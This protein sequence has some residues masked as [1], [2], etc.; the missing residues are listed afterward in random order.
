MNIDHVTDSGVVDLISSFL[1]SVE[2]N[3]S[4]A[5]A[6]VPTTD[7]DQTGK[8]DS[9]PKGAHVHSASAHV[10]IFSKDRPWQLQQLLRSMDLP[11]EKGF[12]YNNI[13]SVDVFI[14]V[15]ASN[16]EFRSGYD[17]IYN[18]PLVRQTCGTSWRIHFLFEDDVEAN[19]IDQQSNAFA[20]LLR[21]SLTVDEGD[22]LQ[23]TNN[24]SYVSTKEDGESQEVVMFLTDDCLLLQPLESILN[25]AIESLTSK[26][27]VFNFVSRLH[28]GIS[29]SQTRDLPSPPPR[30]KFQY[31]SLDSSEGA[32][33]YNRDSAS[34]EWDYPFDLS[35][36]VYHKS[37]VLWLLNNVEP[38]GMRH[39]NFFEIQG[40]EVLKSN[41]SWLSQKP[42]SA[43]PTRPMLVILA[44]NRVQDVCNAPLAFQSDNIAGQ[45]IDPSNT[46]D[47][48]K[49]LHR[50]RHL[51]I[52]HYRTKLYNASHIGDFFLDG[53]CELLDKETPTSA[54]KDDTVPNLSVLIPVHN[55]QPQA[56]AHAIISII[57]QLF[58]ERSK[59]PIL[60]KHG[61]SDLLPMQIVIV[62]D[63]CSDGS[64]DVMLKAVKDLR[65]VLDIS[66]N[67]N[68]LRCETNTAPSTKIFSTVGTQCITIDIVASPQPGVASALNHG[69]N[70][71]QS[72]YVARMDADDIAAPGR[73]LTQ[74]KFMQR[75]TS[76]AAVGT[77]SVL[78]STQN[79]AA[80]SSSML[81]YYNTCHELGVDFVNSCRVFGTS[82]FISDPGFLSWAMLFSCTIQHPSVMYRKSVIQ[83]IGGYDDSFKTSEDYDLWLRLIENDC[84]SVTNLPV[85]G[86]WHRK[87]GLSKSVTVSDKQKK[88]AA[89]ASFN[90]VV[91]LLDSS[92]GKCNVL[93]VQNVSIMRNS[94][95]AESVAEVDTAVFLLQI[96]ERVF[97]K[98]NAERLTP[99]EIKL[100]HLDVDSRIAELA[101]KFVNK[102]M[103]WMIWC[104]RCP[105]QQ[106]ERLSLICHS[107]QR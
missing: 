85:L 88:E 78:F 74:L 65:S 6:A 73:L 9:M 19:I 52:D 14:I 50:D 91:R 59:T 70:Y 7:N 30:N 75:N 33:L 8:I 106:L 34:L 102:S 25:C 69:L 11:N 43:I 104:K 57:M 63:R 76:F 35:G 90:A 17:N 62:D 107:K 53:S 38:N 86:T 1:G 87:H 66:L 46:I 27:R 15:C 3:Q 31:H 83:V 82:L 92:G 22:A 51:N 103:A 47:L 24:Q 2:L 64:I 20:R 93:T 45:D 60:N 49:L 61:E 81:P 23:S 36:G 99:R 13:I 41:S 89:T 58:C 21:R 16:E 68:D 71:C 29:W 4:S 94:R 39:P 48:L 55:G 95:L 28:P 105:N 10:I 32:Y 84:K 96:V 26:P 56:A 67:V 5:P 40:N 12:A 79:D 80:Q 72:E 98:V 37:F 54:I 18:S 44:I 97:I 100:I 101:E 42:F 77:S